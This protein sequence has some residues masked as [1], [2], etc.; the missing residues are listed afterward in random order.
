MIVI[1]PYAQKMSGMAVLNAAAANPAPD[2]NGRRVGSTK[3]WTSPAAPTLARA[4]PDGFRTRTDENS[5]NAPFAGVCRPSAAPES[6][7]PYR[8]DA[9]I[10]ASAQPDGM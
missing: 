9:V 3:P 8:P 5:R 4:T 2:A 7:G 1:P 10:F 6:Y